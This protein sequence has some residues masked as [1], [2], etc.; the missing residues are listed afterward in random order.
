M[1]TLDSQIRVIDLALADKRASAIA[2]G[3]HASIGFAVGCLL[4]ALV[5]SL[6]GGLAFGWRILAVG[7]CVW[8]GTGAGLFDSRG[9]WES[10]RL[11]ALGRR[12]GLD[13]GFI[14]SVARSTG[15]EL[16]TRRSEL[17]AAF[18]A[19]ERPAARQLEAS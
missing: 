2:V 4:G 6:T 9:L 15:T 8:G 14:R 16:Q 13:H 11:R 1:R 5:F 12:L 17:V 19:L 3:T 7:V 10:R 18:E